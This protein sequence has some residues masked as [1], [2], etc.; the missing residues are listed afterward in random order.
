MKKKPWKQGD[1]DGLCGAY[2]VVNAVYYLYR[3]F[4][5]DDC[6]DLFS[7]MVK[8]H[9]DLFSQALVGGMRF[10]QLWSLANGVKDYLAPTRTLNLYRPFYNQKVKKP[11][12]FLDHVSPMIGPRAV[13]LIGFGEPWNHWSLITKITPK[14]VRFQDSDELKRVNRS[15]LALLKKNDKDVE[16]DYH[17]SI[18]IERGK[19]H[20][21]K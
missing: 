15:V 9:T 3:D 1:L 8:N 10:K 19:A 18:V 17:Q 7:F 5:Q 6:E 13:V 21:D 20:R 2:S 12:E 4:S 11:D 16:L 14:S